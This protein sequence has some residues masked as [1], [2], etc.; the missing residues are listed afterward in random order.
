MDDR[1]AAQFADRLLASR[2]VSGFG[3]LAFI[4]SIAGIYGVMAFLVADRTREIGVRIALGASAEHIRRLVIGS[5]LRLIAAGAVLG[6]LGAGAAG[7]WLQ[8]QLY[9]VKAEDPATI[10][11]VTITISAA[12][13]LAALPSALHAARV[14]PK[15]LL[16]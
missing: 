6:S 5:S 9:G 16:R 3:A 2:I 15:V 12:A 14:D 4:I 1:Y 10:A 8:S 11:A 7:R 13:V